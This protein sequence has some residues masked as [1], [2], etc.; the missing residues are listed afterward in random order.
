[1]TELNSRVLPLRV[2]PLIRPVFVMYSIPKNLKVSTNHFPSLFSHLDLAGWISAS[3]DDFGRNGLLENSSPSSAYIVEYILCFFKEFIQ[4]ISVSIERVGEV[5]SPCGSPLNICILLFTRESVFA[6][7]IWI[8]SNTFS[9][10]SSSISS[11]INSG[12][13]LGCLSSS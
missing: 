2:A 9:S 12:E 4:F 11:L 10:P 13:K 5:L 3:S 1:M 8:H 7:C 6:H